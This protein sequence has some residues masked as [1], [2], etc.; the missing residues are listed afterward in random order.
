MRLVP[1]L[2]AV[3]PFRPHSPLFPNTKGLRSCEV[4]ASQLQVGEGLWRGNFKGERK[5]M[6]SYVSALL[7]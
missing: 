6:R 7:H 4:D 1:M 3:L 5:A 2:P